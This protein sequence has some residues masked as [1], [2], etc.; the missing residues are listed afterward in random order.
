MPEITSLTAL[1][2]VSSPSFDNTPAQVAAESAAAGNGVYVPPGTYRDTRAY[3]GLNGRYFGEGHTVDAIGNKRARFVSTITSRPALGTPAAYDGMFNGD[4]SGCHFP[5][6]H[7]VTGANTA[8]NTN[9][10]YNQFR[11]LSAVMVQMRNESG[12]GGT[13]ANG[14][15]GVCAVS[16][17]VSNVSPQPNYTG[18]FW[19]GGVIGMKATVGN[20]DCLSNNAVGIYTGMVGTNVSGVY[21]NPIEINLA[22]YGNECAA[23]GAVFNFTRENA[24]GQYQ[25]SFWAAFRPNS[26][27]SKD[28]DVAFAP[29]GK[30]KYALDLTMAAISSGAIV[31]KANQRVYLNAQQGGQ[32][33]AAPGASYVEYNS[34]AR[35][36]VLSVEGK[37]YQ[38]GEDGNLYLPAG[39]GVYVGGTKVA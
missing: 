6:F 37:L 25:N 4:W 14:G 10:A 32:F 36:I 5:M 26:A 19:A 21:L 15:A 18:C 3:F 23:I 1:G 20:N 28:C 33:C 13:D 29:V 17:D 24:S 11:E 34:T 9:G 31:A 30:W 2:G 35:K 7:R 16:V 12:Y 39:G 38:F 22:D 8:W 27:G